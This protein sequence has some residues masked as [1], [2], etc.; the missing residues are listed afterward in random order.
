[1]M[2]KPVIIIGNG[3]HAKVITDI[4]LFQNRDIIGFTAPQKESNAYQIAYLGKDEAILQFKPDE[5]ELINGIGSVKDTENRKNIYLYFKSC[6]YIFSSVV[7]PSA[8]IANSVEL[9]EG[10][11]IMAGSVIQPFAKIADN[12]IVN[13]SVSIDHDCHIGKHCHIAPGCTFSGMVS[14]GDCSH[15]GTGT[16]IIQNIKIGSHVL[17]GAGSLVIHNI[18]SNKKA[19]GAPAKEV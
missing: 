4:L 16:T 6:N 19:F 13:T 10:V 1:M 2:D 3:G 9:G 15:I 12:T 18:G 14:I 8:L 17:I 5:I 11:Q 7:H